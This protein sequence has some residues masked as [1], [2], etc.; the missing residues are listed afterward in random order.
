MKEQDATLVR[1][2]VIQSDP[3]ADKILELW[4]NLL[5]NYRYSAGAG[6]AL[7]HFWN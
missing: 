4:K 5:D 3:A 2:D 1:L 7:R 6:K